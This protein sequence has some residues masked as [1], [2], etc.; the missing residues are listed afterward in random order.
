MHALIKSKIKRL[1][2]KDVTDIIWLCENKQSDVQAIAANLDYD[3]LVDFAEQVKEHHFADFDEVCK[4]LD[5][6]ERDV[7]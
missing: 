3:S 6:D 2:D 4:A 5:I 1:E 7:P